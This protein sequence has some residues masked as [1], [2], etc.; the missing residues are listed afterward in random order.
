LDA[1]AT[2]AGPSATI[3]PTLDAF[4]AAFDIEEQ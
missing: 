3:K 2:V 4:H 1:V